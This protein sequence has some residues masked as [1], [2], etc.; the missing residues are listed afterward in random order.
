M[1]SLFSPSE[2]QHI[3]SRLN[4]L[5]ADSKPLWGKMNV[6]QMLAHCQWPLR[7]AL[8]EQSV[9]RVLVGIL[10]G[11]FARKQLVKPEPFRKSLPTA[12]EFV[13]TDQ[14]DFVKEK[15][16]LA[17]LIEKFTKGGPEGLT[18]D[19]HPFFGRMTEQEWDVLQWKHLDHHLRQFGV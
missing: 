9:K 6:A 8:G 19:P 5:T 14:R 15:L 12:K 17:A 16:Q 18:E 1:K 10:F 11:G 13:V 2:S 3:I 7:I 4:K